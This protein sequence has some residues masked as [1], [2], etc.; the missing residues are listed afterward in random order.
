ML[1]WLYAPLLDIYMRN[2]SYLCIMVWI[3]MDAHEYI[4]FFFQN[5]NILCIFWS[6]FF[7]DSGL[8]HIFWVD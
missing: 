1:F 4:C 8:V 3:L 7:F 5:L 2:F 6:I